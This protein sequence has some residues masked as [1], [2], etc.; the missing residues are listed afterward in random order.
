MALDLD[1]TAGQIGRMVESMRDREGE[2]GRRLRTALATLQQSAADLSS[3]KDKISEAKVTWLVAGL[4]EPPDAVHS[5][6]VLPADYTVIST[7][8][9][10]IDVD[11]HGPASC[12][13][14]N[15]GSVVLRYGSEPDAF[16]RSEPYLY[17]EEGDLVIRD[18]TS[19][20]E[21]M[22]AGALLGMK[23]MVEECR[24][25]ARLA[26][27][28][29]NHPTVALLD[30][31][32]IL[33]GLT[34]Q[35]YQEFIRRAFLDEGL[36]KELGTFKE[37]AE[38]RPVALASYISYPRST[39]VVNALRVAVCPHKPYPNCDL[40]C[41][42]NREGNSQC[43]T[44]ASHPEG[45][46]ECDEVAGITDRHLFQ[47]LLAPG[48]RSATFLS[49]SSIARD[50]YG[51]HRVHFFYVNVGEEVAR[52]EVPRWVSLR[53][54]LMDLTHAVILDQCRRGQGYPVAI[55]EAHEQAVVTGA[56]REAFWQIV[57]ASMGGSGI[58]PG[59][60]AKSISKLT[61]WV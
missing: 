24:A 59:R 46:R 1:K 42:W 18:P 20:A 6:P 35:A 45:H 36:L 13:L 54:D 21:Q 53:T 48:E 27:E 57:D 52:V 9:S 25:L 51:E 14:I 11:R 39:D 34:G 19:N 58:S 22:V 4:E 55:S 49:Q 29:G 44:C 5:E 30:G 31:S 41:S 23:R 40:H 32:L 56:D 38:A 37:L 10:H 61:R 3:L 15:I 2:W 8:G 16:L 50:H 17:S 12:Y 26:G 7:D 28:H 33:W 47:E 60:S 43:P